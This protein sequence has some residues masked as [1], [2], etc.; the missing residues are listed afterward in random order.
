MLAR[1]LLWTAVLTVSACAS[2]P[3]VVN[4]LSKTRAVKLLD[5]PGASYG[6]RYDRAT[7]RCTPGTVQLL[8]EDEFETLRSGWRGAPGATSCSD[9]KKQ[10]IPATTGYPEVFARLNVSGSAQVMVRLEADG[11]VESVHPVCATDSAFAQAAAE[12]A[13]RIVYSPRECDGVPVRS[14]ILVPFNYDWKK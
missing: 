2:Q 9:T 13:M 5:N 7:G 6:A 8:S 1:F 12:T 4:E 14:V 3:T 10:Q 11:Q